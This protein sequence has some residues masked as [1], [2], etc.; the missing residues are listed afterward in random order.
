MRQLVE[1]KGKGCD[2]KCDFS[3]IMNQSRCERL[4]AASLLHVEETLRRTL[5]S[6]F[7]CMSHG[8]ATTHCGS[9]CPMRIGSAL[10][11]FEFL[12][13]SHDAQS[14]TSAS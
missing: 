1:L 3:F 5:T 9:G 10:L 2:S 12:L 13:V 4:V 14:P 7:E 11:S 8:L 6:A